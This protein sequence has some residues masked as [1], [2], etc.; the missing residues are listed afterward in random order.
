MHV[1]VI[2]IGKPGKNLGW[3]IVGSNPASGTDLDEAID[4]ISDRISRGPVALGFEAPLYVPM[5]R[6]AGELTKARSGECV[7]GV[8]RPYSASAGSTVLVIATVVVP[9]VLRALRSAAPDSVATM[10][11][12][13]FFS[14][15]VGVLFFEAFVT[16]QKKSHDARHVEDAE[17]AAR[18]LL[19]MLEERRPLESAICEPECLNLLGAM[20]LRTGWT[21]DLN[22][23]DDQCLVVRPPVG[24]L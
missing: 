10:D 5:R 21:S 3:A 4:E 20:M 13:S 8:N 17:L 12:R 14:A 24:T 18:H 22:A 6:A 11:Y 1:A 9:Y 19:A 15:P 2:D 7:G 16:N 23:L